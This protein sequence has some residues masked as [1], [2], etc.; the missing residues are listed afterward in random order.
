MA[1][2]DSLDRKAAAEKAERAKAEQ[3]RLA[4]AKQRVA[5]ARAVRAKFDIKVGGSP[6]NPTML[7]L[8]KGTPKVVGSMQFNAPDGKGAREVAMVQVEDKVRRQGIATTL[9]QEAKKAGLKP[10]HSPNR[11]QAGDAFAKST[12]SSVPTKDWFTSQEER[13]QAKSSLKKEKELKKQQGRRRA[14][15]VAREKA[16]AKDPVF[17]KLQAEQNA[18]VEARKKNPLRPFRPTAG[19][20]APPAGTPGILPR[21]LGAVGRIAGPLGMLGFMF[22]AVNQSMN[23]RKP[24]AELF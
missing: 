21:G 3:Q 10:V 7:A 22:D 24:A 13:R 5:K 17:Q 20:P 23:A 19:T 2:P 18:V 9:F 6:N 16:L 4:A 12:G 8:E 11:S 14:M 1:T 15:Q